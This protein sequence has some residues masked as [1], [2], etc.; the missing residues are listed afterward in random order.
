LSLCKNAL[1]AILPVCV[2]DTVA[3]AAKAEADLDI[4]K[5]D[6]IAGILSSLKIFV[7]SFS[8]YSIQETKLRMSHEKSFLGI[9]EKEVNEKVNNF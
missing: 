5:G 7:F 4:A 9:K 3:A 2:C 6:P 8:R 1:I